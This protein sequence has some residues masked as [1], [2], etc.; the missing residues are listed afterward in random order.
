MKH[1]SD[2]T[3]NPLL[4]NIHQCLYTQR[5]VNGKNSENK[6]SATPNHIYF[7]NEDFQ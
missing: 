4:L 2:L 6:P 1:P 5:V 7:W 3:S